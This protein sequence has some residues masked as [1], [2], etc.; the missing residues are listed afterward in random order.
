[1]QIPVKL[2]KFF[3]LELIYWWQICMG[4][5]LLSWKHAHMC[6]NME[7]EALI[8]SPGGKESS[9]VRWRFRVKRC[10]FIAAITTRAC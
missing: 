10:D 8:R 7:A 9:S 6:I 4:R 5:D 2:V 1:M 3:Y